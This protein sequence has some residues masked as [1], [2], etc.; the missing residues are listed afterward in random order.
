MSINFT[1]YLM[2]GVRVNAKEYGIDIFS[3]GWLPY[4]EGH[5]GIGMR[6]VLSETSSDDVYIGKVIACA[7]RSDTDVFV[8]YVP[9]NQDFIDVDGF[10]RRMLHITGNNAKLMFFGSWR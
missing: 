2:I 5:P 6:I 8:Q 4:L 3:D 10:L 9:E 1:A 7:D